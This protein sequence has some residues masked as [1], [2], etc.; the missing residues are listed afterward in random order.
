MGHYKKQVS[1]KTVGGKMYLEY[2]GYKVRVYNRHNQPMPEQVF[3]V[4][5]VRAL[6]V[7]ITATTTGYKGF[8]RVTNLI[9]KRNSTIGFT[10]FIDGLGDG[11]LKLES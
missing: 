10:N 5:D 3:E 2:V 4:V 8:V 6:A 11:T 7:K 1:Q 9:N